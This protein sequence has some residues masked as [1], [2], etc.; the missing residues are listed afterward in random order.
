MR[1]PV[2]IRAVPMTVSEPPSSNDAGGAEEPLGHFQGPDVDAAATWSGRCC[3]RS[4]CR[5]GPAG[6]GCRA[7]RRP[8]CPAR[9][10]AWRA[11][12]PARPVRTWLAVSRSELL[13]MTSPLTVRRMSVTSSGRSSTS[14]MIRCISGWFVATAW[15]MCCKQDRLAGPRRGDDQA[16]LAL[17]DRRQQ[18]HDARGQRL[19][20]GLQRD[21]LVRVDR[22]SARR[23][24]GGG[25][26]SGGWPSICST[27]ASR[28]PVPLLGGSIGPAEQQA[29]AQAEACWM[30]GAGT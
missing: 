11:R 1:M 2:S 13:A 25:Y 29:L 24:C 30:S 10:A 28:G 27:P 19:G 4:C 20:A 22:R 26:C 21:L 23:S 6:S 5:P 3:R 17:A 14:S 18:V 12:R 8:A 15:A 16:A 9:P 7:G